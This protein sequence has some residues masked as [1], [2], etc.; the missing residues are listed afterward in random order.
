[1]NISKSAVNFVIGY[2][3]K[4][5]RKAKDVSVNADFKGF[6][7]ISIGKTMISEQLKLREQGHIGEFQ[8]LLKQNFQE[9]KDL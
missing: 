9:V 4:Q 7:L 5:G 8:M 2:E 6:D 3:E 1:M